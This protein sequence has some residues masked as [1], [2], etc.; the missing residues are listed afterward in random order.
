MTINC[1]DCAVAPGQQHQ[2]G[3]DVARC[4]ACGWQYIG[5]EC[6]LSEPTTWTGRWPGE[7]E[8]EEYGL[9]DLNELASLAAQGL[10]HWDSDTERWCR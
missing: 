10:L 5:C 4:T 3:C 9:K 6:S 2:L 1:G 7:V 8:V